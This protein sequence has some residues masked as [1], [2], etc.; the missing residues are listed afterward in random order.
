MWI[1]AN[2]LHHHIPLSREASATNL[3]RH[4]IAKDFFRVMKKDGKVVAWMLA[5]HRVPEYSKS[6]VTDQLYYTTAL[7]GIEAYKTMV[8]FHELLIEYAESNG[9]EYVISCCSHFDE[10]RKFVKVLGKQGWRVDGYM[11]LWETSNCKL[12]RG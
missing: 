7:K 11:A 8:A 9:S 6:R 5:T 12:K 2:L 10:D 1:D 4:I 3:L